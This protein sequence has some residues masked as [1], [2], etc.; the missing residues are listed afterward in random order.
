MKTTLRALDRAIDDAKSALTAL[1]AKLRSIPISE[2][3]LPEHASA[4]AL[5]AAAIA[6]DAPRTVRDLYDQ[7]KTIAGEVDGAVT[8]AECEAMNLSTIAGGLA[9]ASAYLKGETRNLKHDGLAEDLR[10]DLRQLRAG[11]DAGVGLADLDSTVADLDGTRKRINGKLAEARRSIER[12][13]RSV[14]I[15]TSKNASEILVAWSRGTLD[16]R[17]RTKAIRL[18]AA[19][20]K[21]HRE[22]LA[23]YREAH[24]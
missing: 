16:Q 23:E 8:R 1:D 17:E 5:V 20:S 2:P 21:V 10:A 24:R 9:S 6:R 3:D 4:G 15:A 19:A 12:V 13:S 7:M 18:A 14:P 22:L 11:A